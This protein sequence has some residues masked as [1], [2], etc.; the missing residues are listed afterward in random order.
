MNGNGYPRH[1]GIV[2]IN[3]APMMKSLRV[4]GWRWGLGQQY[5]LPLFVERAGRARLRHQHHLGIPKKL[6]KIEVVRLSIAQM[7]MVMSHK[8]SSIHTVAKGG[9]DAGPIR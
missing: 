5:D 4:E 2:A 3:D 9:L 7:L 8:S 6:F 1:I